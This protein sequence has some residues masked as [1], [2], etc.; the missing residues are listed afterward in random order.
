MQMAIKVVDTIDMSTTVAEKRLDS[1]EDKCGL[2]IN[3]GR[4]KD[5]AAV[6]AVLDVETNQF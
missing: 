1:V 6:K 4:W 5:S 3:Q 2:D